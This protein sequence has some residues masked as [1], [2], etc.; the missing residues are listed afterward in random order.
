MKKNMV[1]LVLFAA[2]IIGAD[3]ASASSSIQL[4]FSVPFAFYAD[5]MLLPAGDYT[6]EMGAIGMGAEHISIYLFGH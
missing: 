5:N 1:L 2:L 6:L 3:I 4:D